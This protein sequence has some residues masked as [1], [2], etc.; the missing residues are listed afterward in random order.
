MGCPNQ[1]IPT[2]DPVTVTIAAA[3][4]PGFTNA[5]SPGDKGVLTL[6]ES[7]ETLTMIYANNQSS[8]TFPP[9][10]DDNGTVELT[11][12]FW[13]GETEVTNAVM[14]AVFQWAYDNGRFSSTVGDP[15]GLDDET[16]ENVTKSGS[17]RVRRGGSWSD[18]AYYLRLGYRSYYYPVDDY[19]TLSFRLASSR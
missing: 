12:K 3:E 2:P 18:F 10:T 6:S 1:G 9:G 13:M 15:N 5:S 4:G 16:I 17:Y 11:T 7:S 8:I 14:V 19:Y